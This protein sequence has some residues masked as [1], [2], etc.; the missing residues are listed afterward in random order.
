[1]LRAPRDGLTLLLAYSGYLTATPALV[2]DLPYDPRRDLAPVAAVM[3]TPH[4]VIVHPSVS[5]HSLAELAEF[6][7]ANPG[8]EYA[9]TGT[10]SVQHIGTELWRQLAG[11]PPLTHVPYRA[12]GPAIADL[13]AGRV[14]LF[15]TTIPPVAGFLRDGRLRALALTDTKRSPTLPDLP[16]AAEA[17]LPRL[18]VVNWNGLFAAAGTPEPIL[19]ALAEATTAAL[20]TPT[21][22]RRIAEQGA[23]PGH[24]TPASLGER[25][26]REMAEAA[27]VVRN[28]GITPD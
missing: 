13:L 27:T 3:D 24:G 11:V 16:T 22:L 2:P 12:V 4:A 15:I 14:R 26:A 25:V 7:R 17:G 6:A 19:A 20:A 10:G 21:A 1:M 28:G 23:E 9:S 8:L 5:V 18:E